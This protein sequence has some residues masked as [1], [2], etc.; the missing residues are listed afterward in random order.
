ML[1]IAMLDGFDPVKVQTLRRLQR[2][3]S[4]MILTASFAGAALNAQQVPALSS[5]ETQDMV[6]R[7]LHVE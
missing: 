2:R 3:I 4:L 6:Q 7:V 1:T 5:A